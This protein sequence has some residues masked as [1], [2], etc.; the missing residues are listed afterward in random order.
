MIPD[1]IVGTCYIFYL[2][3]F[4]NSLKEVSLFFFKI[5][6]S[7]DEEVIGN[8]NIYA[9]PFSL[10]AGSENKSYYY[11]PFIIVVINCEVVSN[12]YELP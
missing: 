4:Q 7:M 9:K 12:S 2:L 1:T 8:S 6:R 10:N 3:N 11:L 5:W